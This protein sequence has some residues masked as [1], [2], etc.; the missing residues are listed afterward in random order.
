VVHEPP[1]P[2]A[3]EVRELIDI[4]VHRGRAAIDEQLIVFE[5]PEQ[6]LDQD[7]RHLDL[8]G[9]FPAGAVA[10]GQEILKDQ[11]LDFTVVESRVADRRRIEGDELFARR[12]VIV[13]R[14]FRAVRRASGRCGTGGL[15]RFTAAH[16]GSRELDDP[17]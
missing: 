3:P 1:G 7:E 16:V 15:R 4:I 6:R 8:I 11:R 5:L 2:L 17:V 13:R 14:R 12:T 9:H 10:A